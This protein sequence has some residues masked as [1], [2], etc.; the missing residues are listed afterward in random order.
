[1]N[2]NLLA[3]LLATLLVLTGCK[4]DAIPTVSEKDLAALNVR[5][6]DFKYLNTRS[7]IS[8]EN[9]DQR[10][11]SPTNIRIRKDSLIWFSVTPVLGIEAARG[12]VTRDSLF[13][14]NKLQ[15]EYHAYSFQE[16]SQKMN[17]VVDFDILQAALLGDP[18][19]PLTTNNRIRRTESETIVMQQ[20]QGVDIINYFNNAT[21][22]LIKVILQEPNSPN[23]LLLQYADFQNHGTNML[24]YTSTITAQYQEKQEMRATV[25]AFQHNKAEFS[26]TAL[27][28][29]FS[30]PDRYVRKH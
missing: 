24:P 8:Y 16:L 14:V 28:F 15:K 11:S 1:M 17:V 25:V 4:R 13:L 23:N 20:Q 26:D 21:L 29:P 7:K 30:I 9:G 2:N 27:S 12:L 10:M 19:V 22:K 18:I 3:L 5:P 6:V